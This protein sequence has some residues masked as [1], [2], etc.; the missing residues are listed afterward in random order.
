MADAIADALRAGP[1][2]P[3]LAGFSGGLDSTVLLH[4]LAADRRVRERGLRAL[5]VRHDLHAAAGAWAEHCRDACAEWGVPM[6][7]VRVQVDLQAGLG[8]EGAAR[9]ARHAAFAASLAAG[10][11]LALAHHRDDQAETVL[12]RLLRAAGGDGLAAMRGERAFGRGRLWRPLL[13]CPR[14]ALLDYARANGLRFVEDPSNAD[15]RFDRNFLRARVLP[16]LR[17]RWPEAGSALARSAA[18]LAADADLLESEA[19][20]R[21]APAR[22]RDPR[23]L[24]TAPLLALPPAWRARALRSWLLSLGLPTPPGR[25]FARIDAELLQS[26]RD[27]Q[28]VFRWPGARLQRWREL[29]HADAGGAP[30]DPAFRCEWD[31]RGRLAL[32]GGGGL[33]LLRDG[34]ADAAGGLPVAAPAT[35]RVGMRQGG[36]RIRLPGRGHSHALKDCLL[37]AGLPPWLRGRVPLLRAGDDELL[38]AGDAILSER[39]H[40][41]Y[42]DLG[43]RL[44]WTPGAA[45]D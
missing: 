23:T 10:E 41:Q 19:Q 36:E 31:G 42:G 33:E 1:E 12:L 34:S 4:A 22:T 6:Q 28:P 16:V 35:L 25:A 38:A 24:A 8:L 32:P 7:V 14:E 17:E 5:H 44:R 18:L 11:I 29:L 26:R 37:Q 15:T 45:R 13:D 43:L 30:G 27:A 40:R 21:L 20:A 9:E 39:W 3:V 2:G